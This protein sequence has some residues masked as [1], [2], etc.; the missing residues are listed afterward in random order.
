MSTTQI[1]SERWIR[2]RCTRW[3][4]L[5]SGRLGF[6]VFSLI[7]AEP[8]GEGRLRLGTQWVPEVSKCA[9]RY[10]LPRRCGAPLCSAS[11]LPEASARWRDRHGK[12]GVAGSSPAEGLA[13]LQ[14]FSYFVLI[15][16]GGR[17]TPEE[18]RPVGRVRG[19]PVTALVRRPERLPSLRPA[20]RSLAETKATARGCDHGAAIG[21]SSRMDTSR[22]G[23]ATALHKCRSGR[24]ADRPT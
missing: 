11:Q 3:C 16:S 18:H 19:S 5:G 6:R 4:G 14:G 23:L 17:G 24:S 2:L 7:P 10:G 1:A 8:A 20:T 13:D 22:E 9:G 15:G 21:V 12:E